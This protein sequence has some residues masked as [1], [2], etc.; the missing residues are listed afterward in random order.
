VDLTHDFAGVRI[1]APLLREAIPDRFAQESLFPDPFAEA[2]GISLLAEGLSDAQDGRTDS[3]AYDDALLRS[4][5]SFSAVF[6]HEVEAIEIRNGRADSAQVKVTPSGLQVVEQLHQATPRPEKVRLAGRLDSIRYSNRAFTMVLAGGRTVRGVL[7][8][9]A[10]EV[11]APLFGR[12][13]TVTGI[14]H[15]RPSGALAR[16]DAE[17][18]EVGSEHDMELWGRVP[19]PL[20][21]PLDL[22]AF[23]RPQGPR[24]GLNAIIGK[25]PGEES[26]E[27][28][29]QLL[30]EL[31]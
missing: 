30:E 26:D 1:A 8:A 3:E 20:S 5:E 4:F 2:S 13:A 24:S 31:S 18:I 21:T 15:F 6:D 16:V 7:A 22:T 25:W 11:L 27:E 9:G 17:H 28:F 12:I 10:A 19:R 23:E 14:A 29:F